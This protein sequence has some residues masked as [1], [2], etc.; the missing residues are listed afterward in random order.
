MVEFENGTKMYNWAKEL[1]PIC[2]SIT[3][4]GV[5]DTLEFIKNNYNQLN[6]ISVPSGTKAFDWEVPFEWNINEAWIKNSN[7]ETVIDFKNNN[8]HIIGY[9]EPKDS[10]MNLDELK[11]NIYTLEYMPNAIPYV[12]SY[13]NKKWGFCMTHNQFKNLSNDIYHVY[14]NTTKTKGE[15]NYGELYIKGESKQEILLSTYICHP[16]MANNEISGPVVVMQL[17]K[18][19]YENKRKYS[20]R[21]VFIPETIGSIVFLSKNLANLKNNVIAGFNITCVGDN[22]SFSFLPS[23]LENTLSDRAALHV[24]K[25]LAPDYIKYS[26]LD[27]GSDERQYCAPGIDLPIASIMRTKYGV[28]PE[29]HTSLDN[30]DLIS[31]EGLN[32]GFEAIKSAIEAIEINCV[33]IIQTLGEPQLGKRGLYPNTSIKGSAN[34]VRTMMNLIS[35][36]DGIYDLIEISNKI[37][38]PIWESN[39]IIQKLISNKILKLQ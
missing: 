2:R 18:W 25:Y 14:I 17:I 12:T 24:L 22:R 35:Y 19:I 1:F 26:W 38:I 39:K 37:N 13:Y 5:R 36:C 33:P 21:I 9:S 7:G 30:L 16:S 20:Y 3:G 31:P 10:F 34:E 11:N 29:Y 23:R 6:I 27:R 32:G 28:Y 4:K 15:L 8:L